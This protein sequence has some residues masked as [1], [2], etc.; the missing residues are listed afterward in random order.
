MLAA[1][2]QL[3]VEHETGHPENADR[4][5]LATDAF[6]LL[7]SLIC[8][9]SREVIR[10][11][12]GLR[13]HGADHGGIL[14]VE[15]ALPEA[16]EGQVVIAAEH[17]I[18]LALGVEHA[19]GGK[20]RVPDLLRAADHQ[21]VLSR[22]AAAIHIAV[23]NPAPLMR[24]ALLLEHPAAVVDPRR[25][26]K[27]RDIEDV[28]EPIHANREVALQIIGEIL[29]QIGVGALVIEIDR[30]GPRLGHS[31]S[32]RFGGGSGIM[33]HFRH[34]GTRW[35]AD[36]RS[37]PRTPRISGTTMIA[38]TP[39]C[40][41]SMSRPRS[42]NGMRRPTSTGPGQQRNSGASSRRT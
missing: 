11:G 19:E 30:D 23:P 27:A 35:S 24:V 9:V 3:A 18:A 6:D 14:D 29:R 20:V 12:T 16:L 26:E 21:A 7:P 40:G 31:G 41:G 34:G 22:L 37:T 5:G 15:L 10:I 17:R 4:F 1:P 2:E 38:S 32:Y 25:A 8:E 33:H 28:R 39:T 36:T 13:Q 42:I